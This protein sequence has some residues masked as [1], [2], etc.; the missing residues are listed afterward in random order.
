MNIAEEI[1]CQFKAADFCWHRNIA[2]HIRLEFAKGIK[3]V[4]VY[5]CYGATW[6]KS[7]DGML[8]DDKD[9]FNVYAVEDWLRTNGFVILKV[10][11]YG[12]GDYQFKIDIT[13]P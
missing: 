13:L 6:Q 5:G 3:F 11:K 1:K 4:T 12:D 7:R 10:D 2:D 9:S 8:D